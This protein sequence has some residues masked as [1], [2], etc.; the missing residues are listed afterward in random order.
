MEDLEERFTKV[1]STAVVIGDKL[2]TLDQE[3]TRVLDT[4]EMME[5]L[6]ALNDPNSKLTRSNNRLFTTLQDKHQLH[7]AARVVKKML[8]FSTELAA[9][10]IGVAVNE[11]ERLSQTI[12]NDLLA[13]F[14]DAQERD[15]FKI[16]RK[17]AES[18][19]E[20]NDKDKVSDRYVWNI[21]KDALAKS[22]ESA[23]ADDASSL[24]PIQDLESLYSKICSI[25][26]E[27]F[28]VI[29]HV[30]PAATC[31]SIREL[32]V[33][34]LFNDP[35]FG[36]FSYLDMMLST[37]ST[38]SSSASTSSTNPEY[39][40]LLCAAYERTCSLA[41]QIEMLEI[42]SLP[43]AAGAQ[44]ARVVPV[45]NAG[46]YSPLGE[47]T[48]L[49]ATPLDPASQL[50]DRE[51]M[52]AFLALQ[53]HSLF[54]SHRQRYFKTE[55][56]LVQTQL[57]E[58]FVAVKFPAPVVPIKQKAKAAKAS[59][60]T[61]DKNNSTSTGGSSSS[62]PPPPLQPPNT[63]STNGLA[64][65]TPSSSSLEK[66]IA[67]ASSVAPPATTVA[68]TES[69]VLAFYESLLA[70]AQDDDI[71]LQYADR[72]KDALER[73]D[74]ILKDNEMRGELITKLFSSFMA[75]FMEDYLAVRA[76]R[77]VRGKGHLTDPFVLLAW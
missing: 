36:I 56:D 38:S 20:Y 12:E 33:E 74:I 29:G 60:K 75:S 9:P 47:A 23:R 42:P 7:E 43:S 65:S 15:Q 63:P 39:V 8:V 55:L 35:A 44:A 71:A 18:L 3:R 61:G 49:A 41:Q 50:G 59:D 37:R 52:R 51:R 27:Q 6:L 21:M 66:E 1:S 28:V 17:C 11:I 46:M 4:D 53:L 67:S 25:C 30:F 13:E 62:L 22:L 16:M 5:A 77:F 69:A 40:R 34:R 57:R 73:C 72:M 24:N 45:A 10:S 54:G 58:L 19:I 2:A 14:S 70:I 26:H 68:T 64:P 48:E 32:L 31:T 76:Y